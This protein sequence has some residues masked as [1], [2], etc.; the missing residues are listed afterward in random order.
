M[1]FRSVGV[2]DSRSICRPTDFGLGARLV[3]DPAARTRGHEPVL[4]CGGTGL[5]CGPRCILRR[6][7]RRTLDNGGS[8]HDRFVLVCLVGDGGCQPRRCTLGPRAGT[9]TS[10][11]PHGTGGMLI[12]A[13][14]S[15]SA[16]SSHAFSD[17]DVRCQA[18]VPALTHARGYP[19]RTDSCGIV[20]DVRSTACNSVRSHK[21]PRCRHAS[22]RRGDRDRPSG[23]APWAGAR[24][25]DPARGSASPV[26]TTELEEAPE[27]H[28]GVGKQ[29]IHHRTDLGLGA[30]LVMDLVGPG[31]HC[32]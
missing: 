1:G 21:C 30:R 31:S 26:L 25:A 5:R 2:R 9:P 20:P 17:G 29:R 4:R 22:P 15:R 7:C 12:Q 3:V 23:S 14:P 13:W 11:V 28:A 32:M 18:P 24:E 10:T 16:L 19:R 27:F 6:W 8:R